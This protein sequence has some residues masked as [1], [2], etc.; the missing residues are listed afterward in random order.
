MYLAVKHGF[1]DEQ[2]RLASIL[3]TYFPDLVNFEPRLMMD[4]E[5]F[6]L[7]LFSSVLKFEEA[8]IY[9]GLLKD[10]K[11]LNIMLQEAYMKL[12]E[13]DHRYEYLLDF[14]VQYEQ[15]LKRKSTAS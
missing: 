1:E 15:E 4:N 2:T 3:Q 12:F 7:K 9:I 6:M 10:I 5:A 8:K 13:V 11:S 14:F